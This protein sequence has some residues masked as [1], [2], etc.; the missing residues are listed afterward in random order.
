MAYLRPP[1]FTQHI[2]NPLAMRFGVGNAWTLSVPGRR[3]GE[4]KKV[5]VIPL[6]YDGA[7]Y[8][9]ST[10]GDSAW[11][12]NVRASNGAAEFG[13]SGNLQP[14]RLTDVPVEQRQPIIDAYREK[15]G[16]TVKGYFEKL[17]NPSDH[18]VFRIEQAQ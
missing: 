4:P 3:S 1:W 16:G 6:D 9:V 12:R 10:R 18:P 14:V 17:P 2:F 7:R 8:L 13:R 5:P 15:V 11:V